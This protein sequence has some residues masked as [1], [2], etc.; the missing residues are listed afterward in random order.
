MTI[1][2]LAPIFTAVVAFAL[3]V[4]FTH[5]K[6]SDRPQRPFPGASGASGSKAIPA[7]QE[8]P[9][10]DAASRP[11]PPSWVAEARADFERARK[12]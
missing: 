6:T 3:F 12:H 11:R 10:A 7:V 1:A 4:L 9:L 2:F 8:A 5:R